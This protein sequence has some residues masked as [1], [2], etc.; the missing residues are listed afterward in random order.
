MPA[1]RPRLRGAA[2]L[3]DAARGRRRRGREAA[4]KLPRRATKM[5]GGPAARDAAPDWRRRAL[6]CPRPGAERGAAVGA[7]LAGRRASTP[8]PRW[9]AYCAICGSSRR[10]GTAACRRSR[11]LCRATAVQGKSD[12]IPPQLAGEG[13]ARSWPAAA[14]R[15]RC[16]PP[17]SCGCAPAGRSPAGARRSQGRCLARDCTA[18]TVGRRT[19]PVS[20]D[21]HNPDPAYQ[22]GRLFAVLG[23]RPARGARARSTPPSATATSAPPPPRRPRS[24]RCCIRTPR[25][26]W[27]GCARTARAA[28]L[29]IEREIGRDRSTALGTEPSAHLG[30][31]TRAASP[32]ATTTSATAK[33][34]R[35]GGRGRRRAIDTSDGERL[36]RDRASADRHDSSA[37]RRDERQPERRPGCR[38]HAAPRPRDRAGPGHRRLP[39]AQDPQLRRAGTAATRRGYDIYMQERRRAE[40]S[41]TSGPTSRG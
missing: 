39:E 13:C 1:R 3:F 28:R 15:A 34:R 25:T 35:A 5:R 36:N 14:I 32:S 17:R 33:R 11:L 10:P 31:R 21:P 26:I 40:P 12:N 20:L 38:Q 7:L 37:V 19:L 2:A 16:S 29:R 6:P 8:S 18:T 41:S 24:S 27:P 22:L 30:S 23:T 4:R 9:P